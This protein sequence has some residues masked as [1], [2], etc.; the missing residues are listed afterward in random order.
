VHKITAANGSSLVKS[1]R[2][3]RSAQLARLTARPHAE[4]GDQTPV[5]T[6]ESF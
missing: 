6:P 3:S 4:F 1:L 2:L 5:Q